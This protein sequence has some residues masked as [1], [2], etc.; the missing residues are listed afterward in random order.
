MLLIGVFLFIAKEVFDSSKQ[1]TL[2]LFLFCLLYLLCF[3][4]FILLF[5]G[6]V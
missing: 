5:G 3:H 2:F 4:L 6:T 1:A